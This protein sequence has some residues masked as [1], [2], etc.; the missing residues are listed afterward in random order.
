M[1]TVADEKGNV[2]ITSPQKT[3]E[4]QKREVVV[5]DEERKRRDLEARVNIIIINEK[6]TGKRI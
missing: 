2:D 6:G 1:K 5:D 4:E 3:R